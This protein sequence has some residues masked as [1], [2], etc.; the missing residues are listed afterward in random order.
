[1]KSLLYKLFTLLFIILKTNTSH[2]Y[3]G[4]VLLPHTHNLGI[5]HQRDCEPT[6]RTYGTVVGQKLH[7]DTHIADRT[8]GTHI[9]S[10]DPHPVVLSCFFFDNVRGM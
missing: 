5:F 4:A 1:M 9:H 7:T 3:C 6:T 8:I 10:I 2:Q